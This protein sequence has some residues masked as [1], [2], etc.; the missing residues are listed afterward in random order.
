LSGTEIVLQRIKKLRR[1]AK[2]RIAFLRFFF[3]KYTHRKNGGVL[4][5]QMPAFN[6][7]D[8]VMV[9]TREEI[10]K[11][12]DPWGALNRCGFMEE[13]WKYCGTRQKVLKRVERFL[14]ERDYLVKRARGVVILEN[15]LC[16][17]TIDFGKCD[18]TCFFFWR[19]EWLT[20]VGTRESLVAAT[21]PADLPAQ[22]ASQARS[23]GSII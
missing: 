15:V 16:A 4:F 18:R 9:R 20:L 22:H 13:M 2:R 14:D 17:G 7:G 11:T 12:L 21:S 23:T 19:D 5:L 10:E 8:L 1:S 3:R 6:T